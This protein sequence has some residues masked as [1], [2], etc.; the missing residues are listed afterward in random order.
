MKIKCII[1]DDEPLAA[2][3]IEMHLKEFPNMELLSKFTNPL[4]ALSIIESGEID[5]VF[6]DI[7]MPVISGIEVVE[8][9]SQLDL[10]LHIVF[11]TA[12]DDFAIKAFE[13]HAIDY[14]LKPVS[15]ERINLCLERI[16][17]D[18]SDSSYAIK[19]QSVLS[20]VAKEKKDYCCLHRG[21][22]IVPV[23]LSEIVYVKAENKG[24][25]IETTKGQFLSSIQ[26]GELEKRLMHEYKAN[27]KLNIGIV[28]VILFSLVTTYFAIA[29]FL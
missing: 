25:V 14:I 29:E 12:Y 1:I 3:V 9:I 5:V 23:K 8:H 10:D 7:N 24:T 13:L 22:K 28:A 4:E 15:D 16:V 2:E 6:I 18:K 26:L 11:V 20:K 21:G 27:T 17:A 19:I